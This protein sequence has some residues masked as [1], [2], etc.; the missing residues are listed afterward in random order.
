MIDCPQQRY[1]GLPCGE[2]VMRFLGK[3]MLIALL[4]GILAAALQGKHGTYYDDSSSGDGWGTEREYQPT[5]EDFNNGRTA[6]AYQIT[7]RGN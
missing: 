2:C 4:I 3:C 5:P 7:D 1:G 6:L